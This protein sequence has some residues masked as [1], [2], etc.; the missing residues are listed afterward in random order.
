MR[1]FSL[2]SG[3]SG[4]AF[5]VDTGDA[6]LLIDCGVG[7]RV[8]RKALQDLDLTGRLD[9]I[10]LSHEHIDHV[11][12]LKS[13]LR[14]ESCPVYATAGTFSAIGRPDRAV[15][16]AR[17]NHIFFGDAVVTPVAVPHDGAEPCG[18]V[19]E[20][21]DETL[22]LFTDLGTSTSDVADAI[23]SADFVILESNYD[24]AMLRQS[25]YPRH[26]KMRIRGPGGHLSNDDCA[27]LLVDS[28]ARRAR[29]VWLAHLSDVNNAPTVA[30]H[31]ARS[32]LSATG[33]LLPILA[34]PRY[35]W[36]ELDLQGSQP[37]YQGQ[38]SI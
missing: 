37:V 14:T 15:Q 21:G 6:A 12:A 17:G 27:G 38:L 35:D 26:L 30:E 2:G 7:V 9:A 23:Q 36:I 19:V 3:S 13:M 24:E 31:A 22:A 20:V 1:V 11:R 25:G 28:T 33:R 4:N 18:F 34:L 5:L 29:G 8:I 10:I 16:V 32:A